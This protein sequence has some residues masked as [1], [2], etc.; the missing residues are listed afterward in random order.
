MTTDLRRWA[1]GSGSP[2]AAPAPGTVAVLGGSGGGVRAQAAGAERAGTVA[3][4]V[5]PG[6]PPA[7]TLPAIP[8]SAAGVFGGSM[9][10]TRTCS[11][12]YFIAEHWDVL[13]EEVSPTA[14]GRPVFAV[15]GR[16]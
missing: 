14:G 10:G 9:F 5:P 3:V 16:G 11:R 6:S 4:A 13:R 8:G 2:G 7:W 12:L 1:S 15:P